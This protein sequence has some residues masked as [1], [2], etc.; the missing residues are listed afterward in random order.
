[1][2]R[3]ASE[4]SPE[5]NRAQPTKRVRWFARSFG[6]QAAVVS[7]LAVLVHVNAIPNDFV[8][9]DV[10][11]IATNRALHKAAFVDREWVAW[12]WRPYSWG[13][14]ER[15]GAYR[16]LTI[17]TYVANLRLSGLAPEPFHAANVL[18]H[19]AVSVLVLAM[20][21]R[22]V[23]NTGALIG[24]LLFAVHPLHTEAVTS[25]VG[26]AELL[27]ALFGL[28][29]LLCGLRAI[30]PAGRSWGWWAVAGAGLFALAVLSKEHVVTLPLWLV[31]AMLVD[32]RRLTPRAVLVTASFTMVAVLYA[33]AWWTVLGV[34]GGP[35]RGSPD[36]NPTLAASTGLRWLTASGVALRYAWLFLWPAQLSAD[37]SFAEILPST[38]L[39]LKEAAGFILVG[40]IVVGIAVA[41]DRLALGLGLIAIPFIVVSNF[42][43]PIG[44]IMA[45]RLTYLPSAGACLVLG[46][47]LARLGWPSGAAGSRGHAGDPAEGRS[48]ALF[49]RWRAGLA[50]AIVVVA[51][52]GYGARSVLRNRDW[53]DQYTLFSATRKVSTRSVK[54]MIG[55][56]R[57]ELV[58]DRPEAAE[59]LLIEAL[60][61]APHSAI[62]LGLLGEAQVRQGRMEQGIDSYRR[63]LALKPD[64]LLLQHNLVTA[65]LNL[66]R[67][68]EAAE[69]LGRAALAVPWAVSPRHNLGVLSWRLGR[70]SDAETALRGALGLAPA[71]V[72]TRLALGRLLLET[73]RTDEA[74]EQF[75]EVLRVAPGTPAALDGMRATNL[76][77]DA[78]KRDEG[79][80][81]RAGWEAGSPRSLRAELLPPERDGPPQ[82]GWR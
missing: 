42:P 22:L 38:S 4:T 80:R 70:R 56:A 81:Y 19:A 71:S 73:G 3:P 14:H 74:R 18:L 5:A 30:E 33:W 75:R 49:R 64:L 72:P 15:A 6:A 66:G 28:A 21:R 78:G 63:A 48:T 16:P 57:E 24:A 50:L 65:Y 40:V 27:A 58:R 17:V 43:F 52:V 37:Y 67:V 23:G 62:A 69:Q 12:F 32:R 34:W 7:L 44:T 41:V 26:R 36:N 29:S 39:G 10:T 8:F 76:H 45:E 9:D 55:L 54:A 47:A 61:L 2:N 60:R 53:Q 1:M 82:T 77:A 79:T 68:A 31:L 20:G 11:V 46:G 35:F 51:L 13:A 25:I 59:P